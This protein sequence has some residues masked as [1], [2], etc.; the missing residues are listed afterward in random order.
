MQHSSLLTLDLKSGRRVNLIPSQHPADIY[1]QIAD[2]TSRRVDKDGG[3]QADFWRKTQ[4]NRKLVKVA[5]MTLQYGSSNKTMA[6]ETAE[7][8][9]EETGAPPPE[10]PECQCK[11]QEWAKEDKGCD[12]LAKYLATKVRLAANELLPG[13]ANMMK[14][15][16]QLAGQLAKRGEVYSGQREPVSR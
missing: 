13:P 11:C 14:T 8:F 16:R 6:K 5:A 3:W 10:Q 7:A 15:I 4:I 2:R 9:E 1:S 12:K